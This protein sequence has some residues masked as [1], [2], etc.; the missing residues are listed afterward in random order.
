[1]LMDEVITG[2]RWSS[3]GAQKALGVT[4]D[5]C[6]LAKI[7]AGGLPGGAVAGKREILDQ[8]RLRGHGGEEARARSPIPAPTTP[9]RC[10]PPRP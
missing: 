10:R 3:G 1:M 7:V 9:I 8:H 5:L 2:F 6:I 4:P